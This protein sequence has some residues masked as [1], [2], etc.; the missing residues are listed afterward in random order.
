MV[1]IR[2]NPQTTNPKVKVHTN[3]KKLRKFTREKRGVERE[4][5][6]SERVNRWNDVID[7]LGLVDTGNNFSDLV[8]H[9]RFHGLK[10]L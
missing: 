6:D 1:W 10:E 5:K 7:E 2:L 3:L 9:F 8:H 4:E